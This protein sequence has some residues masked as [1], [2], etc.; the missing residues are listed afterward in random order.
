VCGLKEGVKS[1]DYEVRDL[2]K[3]FDELTDMLVFQLNKINHILKKFEKENQKGE[4][5]S[6][7]S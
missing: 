3:S 1:G 7:Q 2:I 6:D 4:I 5:R